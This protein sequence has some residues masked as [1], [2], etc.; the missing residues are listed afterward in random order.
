MHLPTVEQEMITHRNRRRGTDCRYEYCPRGYGRSSTGN[1][2]LG[3]SGGQQ[4]ERYQQEEVTIPTVMTASLMAAPV[5]G[6]SY[7]SCG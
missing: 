7:H 4:P 5:W 3:Y 2:I 1:G 6:D